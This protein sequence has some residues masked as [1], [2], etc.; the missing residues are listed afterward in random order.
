[1]NAIQP[2]L[3]IWG[4]LHFDN[5]IKTSNMTL[6]MVVSIIFAVYCFAVLYLTLKLS[7]RIWNHCKT[8]PNDPELDSCDKI[9][10][11][12]GG[13][14]S[15]FSFQYNTLKRPTAYYQLLNPL[16]EGMRVLVICLLV[17]GIT[18]PKVGL[19]LILLV[20]FVRLCY[21]AALFKVMVSW[22]YYG[23]ELLFCFVFSMFVA[24]KLGVYSSIASE[25]T[26]QKKVAV[27]TAFLIVLVRFTCL[28]SIIWDILVK[29]SE[30]RS[31]IKQTRKRIYQETERNIN[32]SPM[33]LNIIQLQDGHSEDNNS[34]DE[35]K[36]KID[37]DENTY[38]QT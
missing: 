34:L 22:V 19:S 38:P 8:A 21:R 7:T 4:M 23:E 20:E 11:K 24:S 3:C 12:V 25:A 5:H 28:L 9:T 15:C 16:V 27:F 29:I 10:N 30:Y 37:I 14:L 36:Q 6:G 26:F 1:M 13:W 17:V 18:N 31:G 33:T 2:S 35:R 32:D